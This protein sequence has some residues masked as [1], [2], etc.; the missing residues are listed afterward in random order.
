M[1]TREERDR[2]LAR[3]R[4][5]VLATGGA[6]PASGEETSPVLRRGAAMQAATRWAEATGV[7]LVEDDRASVASSQPAERFLR[8]MRWTT[9]SSA[10]TPARRMSSQRDSG[11]DEDEFPPLSARPRRIRCG[12]TSSSVGGVGGG[13]GTPPSPEIIALFRATKR[14]AIEIVAAAIAALALRI[15]TAQGG[16]RAQELVRSVLDAPW[17]GAGSSRGWTLLHVACEQGHVPIA[18]LLLERG[19]CPRCVHATSGFAPVHF[20]AREG[21]VALLQLLLEGDADGAAA[22]AHGWTALHLAAQGDHEAAAELLLAHAPHALHTRTAKRRESALHV[23]ARFGRLALASLLLA[24]HADVA[25]VD[26]HGQTPLEVAAAAGHAPMVELLRRFLPPKA[27]ADE[28][29]SFKRTNDEQG[30]APASPTVDAGTET[31][32]G[33]LLRAPQGHA[34]SPSPRAEAASNADAQPQPQPTAA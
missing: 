25:A 1:M 2:Q 3:C 19:A 34:R 4:D 12:S 22:E 21:R 29:G 17:T 5:A 15:E 31:D 20:A 30:A 13:L 33:L 10:S 7:D 24:A 8:P 23:A 9:G 27:G 26:C 14:G 32:D 28:Q 18:Q 11:S 16:V 6:S